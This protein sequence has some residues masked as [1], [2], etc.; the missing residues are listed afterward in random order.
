VVTGLGAISPI[1]LTVDDYWQ[2]LTAG[3]SGVGPITQFDASNLNVR[4]AAEVKDFDAAT[5]TDRKAARRMARFVQFSVAAS[6]MALADSGLTITAEN[7]YEVGTVI[8]TGGGGCDEII[9]E[10]SCSSAGRTGS[11]RS[12]CQP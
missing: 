6:S 9:R 10:T 3:R 8:A 11:T 4:I 7:E 5:Y 1:G 12:S 2:N